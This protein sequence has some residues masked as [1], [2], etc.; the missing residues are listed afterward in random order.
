MYEQWWL[1]RQ[2]LGVVHGVREMAG[3]KQYRLMAVIQAV[4]S[5][6]ALLEMELRSSQTIKPKLV[7]PEETPQ[8]WKRIF[9]DGVNHIN[10]HH[11][12]GN[13]RQAPLRF[14]DTPHEEISSSHRAHQPCPSMK[15]ISISFSNKYDLFGTL[16]E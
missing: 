14:W 6:S 9:S 13:S 16:M 7:M 15:N 5:F 8:D 1:N 10:T 3:L 4:P 2:G 12:K 11:C